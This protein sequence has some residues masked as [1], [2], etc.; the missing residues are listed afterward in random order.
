MPRPSKLPIL[1]IALL[2]GAAPIA[3]SIPYVDQ[4]TCEAPAEVS[5]VVLPDGAGTP[6]TQARLA[7]GPAVD[8]TIRARIVDSQSQ[9]LEFFPRE[10]LWLRFAAPPGTAASCSVDGDIFPGGAFPADA[11]ADA[12][13]W[14]QW[15]APLRGG[16]WSEGPVTVYV[17]GAPAVRPDGTELPSVAMRAN[18]PDINGDMAVDLTDIV[19]FSQGFGDGYHYSRDYNWDGVVNMVDIVVFAQAIASVCP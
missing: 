13:G 2:A 10:D 5:I 17:N 16:G 18:S 19:L 8:A 7:G 6:L 14:T 1:A 4:V 12:D 9:P 15:A 11:A 3:A